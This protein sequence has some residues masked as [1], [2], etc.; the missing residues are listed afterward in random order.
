VA[1][2]GEDDPVS[3]YVVNPDGSDLANLTLDS[4]LTSVSRAS[5]SPDGSSIVL[6]SRRH[7]YVMN[8]DGSGRTDLGEG[9]SAAWS[10]DGSRIAYGTGDRTGLFIAS[11]DPDGSNATRLTEGALPTWSPDGMRIAYT[12]YTDEGM[13]PFVMNADGSGQVGLADQLLID[14]AQLSPFSWSPDGTQIVI[15]RTDRPMAGANILDLNIDIYIANTDGSGVR[16]LTDHPAI[17]ADPV[18]CPAIQ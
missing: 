17:D 7:I 16:R 4:G 13:E 5:W 2:G 12:K 6:Q 14:L 11:I 9:F 3:A 1:Q 8:A 10:P 15:A 18:W